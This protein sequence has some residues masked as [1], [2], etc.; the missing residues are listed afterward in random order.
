MFLLALSPLGLVIEL[1]INI[2]YFGSPFFVV[3][4]HKNNP[5]S[6]QTP[7][8]PPLPLKEAFSSL[9]TLLGNLL[10][11]VYDDYFMMTLGWS[12]IFTFFAL[13]IVVIGFYKKLPKDYSVY[14]LSYILFFSSFTWTISAPR[15]TL[16]LFPIFITLSMIKN[17]LVL[18]LIIAIFFILQLYFTRIFVN[19]SWAF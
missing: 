4:E 16:P 15:F 11:G 19:G 6:I 14:A 5:A 9:P 17:R 13:I 3:S 2:Y 1:L 18:G 7:S 8:F 12:A 10:T